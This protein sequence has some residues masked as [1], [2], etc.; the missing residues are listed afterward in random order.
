MTNDIW[1]L[2]PLDFPSYEEQGWLFD[3]D[4]AL[5]D[6]MKGMV[7]SD[8][9]NRQRNVEAWFGHPDKELREQKYPYV[10]VDMLQIQE[11]PKR[12]HRGDLY[13]ADPPAWWG[14]KPLEPWQDAYLLEMPHPVDIDYQISTWARNP[15]HDRQMLFQLFTGGRTMLRN[16]L[17][18]TADGKIRRLDFLGHIK[19]D[20]TDPDGKRLFNNVFRVR[21]SSE[22]PWGIIDNYNYGFGVVHSIHMR[23]RSFIAEHALSVDEVDVVLGTVVGRHP[24][25]RTLDLD[26]DGARADGVVMSQ[27]AGAVPILGATV[28]VLRDALT[29]TPQTPSDYRLVVLGTEAPPHVEPVVAQMETT[30]PTIADG[31]A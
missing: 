24:D 6:L 13:L 10:T 29:E 4:R 21:V 1:P 19:R 8:H 9:E 14:L 31:G 30:D 17:L 7:V 28:A 5:R 25:S 18:Y 2:P 12:A 22:V 16:G 26:L 11:D 15:R 27:E 20:V 23:I 3:E